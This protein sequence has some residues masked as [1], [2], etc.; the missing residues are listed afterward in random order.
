M[1]GSE[2]PQQP[3]SGA[4]Q[5]GI[6]CLLRGSSHKHS[7]SVLGSQEQNKKF[8]CEDALATRDGPK[9]MDGSGRSSLRQDNA[10]SEP[11]YSSEWPAETFIC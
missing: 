5:E 8:D 10:V 6:C 2:E 3:A 1:P 11:S 4:A 7:E 9:L